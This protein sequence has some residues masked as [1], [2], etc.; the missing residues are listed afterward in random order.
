MISLHHDS[1]WARLIWPTV[2]GVFFA[3]WLLPNQFDIVFAYLLAHFMA[4]YFREKSDVV[5]LAVITT[6]LTVIGSV[7]KPQEAPM[8]QVMLERV[9]PIMSFWAA[10][11]FVVRYMTLREKET[12]KEDRFRALFEFASSG[13]LLTDQQGSIVMANP[14]IEG[15]FGYDPDELLGQSVDVLVPRNASR[16]H[17][18]HR[19]GY[20]HLPQPRTMG[21][22]LE[23]QG[24]RKDGS[25]FP[26]E[27]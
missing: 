22:G 20:L 12:E 4:I 14:A 25:T 17:S 24:L 3:D 5:L 7:L 26:V 8:S 16:Q 10:A 15:L 13:I 9:P 18:A 23:L 6:V 2:V 27:V 11:F 19:Q 21:T 1:R